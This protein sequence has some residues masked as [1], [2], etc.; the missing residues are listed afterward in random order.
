MQRMI[1]AT[2]I[3]NL[4]VKYEERYDE[5]QVAWDKAYTEL[6]DTNS[7]NEEYDAILDELSYLNVELGTYEC[8][9]KDLKRLI[10]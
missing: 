3:N 1:E 5:C 2:L 6:K 4:L 10:K 9:V 7:D 8:I